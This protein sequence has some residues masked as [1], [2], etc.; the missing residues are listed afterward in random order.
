MMPA[1]RTARHAVASALAAL[2]ALSAAP[3][4]AAQAGL[5]CMRV[6]DCP[7]PAGDPLARS[8]FALRLGVVVEPPDPGGAG[9]AA[10]RAGLV[11]RTDG[12]A[13]LQAAPGALS[14]EQRVRDDPPA[15]LALGNG[16]LSRGRLDDAARIY[17]QLQ[18]LLRQKPDAQAH[19]CVMLNLG[20]LA[21]LRGRYP[22][23]RRLSEEALEAFRTLR[24]AP[25]SPNS[26]GSV[27][28]VIA[29]AMQLGI[30]L[31]PQAAQQSAAALQLATDYPVMLAASAGVQNARLNLANLDAR[32]GRYADAERWLLQALDAAPNDANGRPGVGQRTVLAELALLY[33]QAGRDADAD[34]YRRRAEALG[35]NVPSGMDGGAVALGGDG[36]PGAVEVVPE[37]A[38][39]RR[40]SRA[41]E[42][43][44]A[45]WSR[46]AARLE[47]GGDAAAAADAWSRVATLAA[48]VGQPEREQ[49]ALAQL[50]RLAAA[51][52]SA[53]AAIWFGKRALNA[54]QGLRHE[55]DA[56]PRAQRQA[57]LADKRRAY[58]QLASLLLQRGRLAEA[59]H[60][61]RLLKEDEGQ[62]FRPTA[63]GAPRG[64]M[65]YTAAEAALQAGTADIVARTRALEA[66][67]TALLR[68][69][70]SGARVDERAQQE[71]MRRL[72]MAWIADSLPG[73]ETQ[74]A[75]GIAR[76]EAAF[77]R[78]PSARSAEE[79]ELVAQALPGMQ[80]L[81]E[82]MDQFAAGLRGL[83]RD[84]A[85][86][87]VP[88]DRTELA[89]ID[90]AL[91]R[92]ATLRE[93]TRR[94]LAGLPG[95]ASADAG[96]SV[97][98]Q[99]P[100]MFLGRGLERPWAIDREL[101]RLD[102]Q[103]QA[104]DNGAAAALAAAPATEAWQP[105]DAAVLDT[106]VRLIAALPAG[107]VALY[108]VAGDTQLD[109][110]MVRRDGRRAW[111]LPIAAQGLAQQV[112][113]LRSALLDPRADPRPPARALHER[114]LAPL[115]PALREASATTLLLSLDGPLRQLPFAAL[116]DGQGWLAE[117][118]AT[119]V[120][121]SAAPAA[122]TR[123]PA[124][125]WRVAAFGGSGGG[126]GLTPLPGV[127]RELDGVVADA[128]AG[129]HGALPGIARL[130]RGFTAASL[131]G[132][133]REHFDVVHIASHFVLRADDPAGSFL[134][135][136]DGGRLGLAELA[137]P[138]WR[139]DGV[140]L[141]TLS[142]CDTGLDGA[143]AFG[144]DVEGLGTLLQGQGAA[145]VLASL[146]SVADDSTAQ[147][148]RRFYALH[149]RQP[150]KAEALRAAQLELI[151]G[152]AVAGPDAG[153]RG[154]QRLPE[155]GIA[156]PGVTAAAPY[157]HPHFWAP[158]VLLGNTL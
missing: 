149:E 26:P 157:A 141:V 120:Y 144:Q 106:G 21:A 30:A 57:Y 11:A 18:T 139:F 131:R 50:Q 36:A 46:E 154:A 128:A 113:A 100:S 150:G 52:G 124:A 114:L 121:T 81:F 151:R 45:H 118:Y 119:A 74:S 32:L 14:I 25:A 64:R 92:L 59:E 8:G 60:T 67:R 145:A 123:R 101:E 126:E 97:L 76:L 34:V 140:S 41:A 5:A 111:R 142:A 158:F 148:M 71:Q 137:A 117:R 80:A 43:A 105:E 89:T 127:R 4:A 83:R 82:I 147:L 104:L 19:A 72:T 63:S 93:R 85:G 115:E 28:G 73:F 99:M 116:H 77:G 39:R 108:F 88:L 122:L 65:P 155:G 31:D 40:P 103:R 12:K 3:P 112:R 143:D 23:A 49:A 51:R 29:R 2:A 6:F 138:A 24:P 94:K 125:R 69:L 133:L 136:G 10:Q 20:V 110:L 130:D 17:A 16:Q 58:V 90:A 86:F 35:Q 53:D 66:E 56:L 134:L 37:E 84:G 68:D 70:T 91:D 22:E 7:S 54:A 87:E 13:G 95:G 135:L 15:L 1:P 27:A 79:R 38:Q 9:L 44:H 42:A 55:L 78:A 61:L 152:A 47:E 129:T 156:A 62:Q 102:A 33:R 96:S 132:A 107:T 153:P 48:V 75:Q 98:A 146:W 109:V